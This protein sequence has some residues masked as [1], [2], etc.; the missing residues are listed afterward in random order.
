MPTDL[1]TARDDLQEVGYDFEISD[2]ESATPILD[3]KIEYDYP[4]P[5]TLRGRLSWWVG[6]TCVPTDPEILPDDF[7][8]I[9]D[10]HG[11]V[12][13]PMGG[14]H[15]DGTLYVVCSENGV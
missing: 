6:I 11:L 3:G 9:A 2:P 5:E 13:Q 15:R 1:E 4:E 10:E 14:S 8:E 12:V 7:R